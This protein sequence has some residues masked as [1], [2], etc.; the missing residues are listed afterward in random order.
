MINKQYTATYQ[1]STAVLRITDYS[2]PNNGRSLW[3]ADLLVNNALKNDVFKYNSNY[4]NFQL[5]QFCFTNTDNKY[6]FIPAEGESFAFNLATEEA[7]YLPSQMLSTLTF[8]GNYFWNN[9]LIV[10]YRD[11]Y[12][13]VDL[14][15]NTCK[16]LNF[17]SN[18]VVKFSSAENLLT[19]HLSDL[20]IEV[21]TL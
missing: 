8:L 10:L 9:T 20:S 6:I 3:Q 5:D 2:E 7:Y 18:N 19:L 14:A 11:A 21:I 13:L 1:N 17:E 15:S 16:T 12:V 4:L